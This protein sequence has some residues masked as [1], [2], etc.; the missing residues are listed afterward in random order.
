MKNHRFRRGIAVLA[1]SACLGLVRPGAASAQTNPAM[2]TLPLGDMSGFRPVA[3]NWRTVGGVSADLNQKEAVKTSPGKG[4]LVNVP[5]EKKKDNLTTT[6]EHGDLELELDFMMAKGSNSG[7][8]L[9]GRYEIQLFD[10][11]GVKSAGVHDLGAIYERWDD[12]KPEGQKGYEGHAPRVNVARAPGL[13]QHYR[14]SFQAPRFNAQGQK[15]QNAR[16]LEIALNGVTLHENVE[17][18]GPTRGP[19]APNEVAMGPLYFQGDHGPVAFRNIRYRNYDKAPVEL[20]NLRYGYYGKFDREPDFATLKADASGTS[21]D[22]TWEVSKTPN[23]FVLRYTGTM[24]IKEPGQY[25]F[26]L[27]SAGNGMLKVADK[28]L[29]GYN[30]RDRQGSVTLQPGDQPIEIVYAKAESWQNPALGVFV[31]GPGIRRQPLHTMSSVPLRNPVDPIMLKANEIQPSLLR[32]FV[33]FQR[34]GDQKSKRIV[35]AISVG[36]AQDVHYTMD[37]DNGALVQVWKG[38]FLDTTPMWHD[39]GDGSS[40]PLGSVVLLN[41]APALTVLGN[42]TAAWP[43]TLATEAAYRLRGYDIDE[44][45]H[46]VFKYTVYGAEVEDR[47]MPEE[48]GKFLTRHVRISGANVPNLYYRVAEGKD[49]VALSDGTYG[50]NGNQYYVRVADAGSAKPIVRTVNNR[51]ELLVAISGTAQGANLRYSIIW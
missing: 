2:T 49:V 9:Q 48:N 44:S 20:A 10:S 47:L 37:L 35:H 33:D 30:Q 24:K 38:G 6:F 5:G 11:W 40:R 36:D 14:I 21:P 41:D 34:E 16:I 13:W 17:L 31:E 42:N 7:V 15:I 46:P 18:T 50:V 26:Q 25:T 12:S 27:L 28:T 4:I 3:D 45:G 39:R 23:D 43:D 29:V 22:L 32:S 51:Q 8:Y 1:W 19:M